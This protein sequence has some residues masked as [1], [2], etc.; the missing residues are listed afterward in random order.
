M[1]NADAIKFMESKGYYMGYLWHV[2]DVKS[3]FECTDEEAYEIL[4]EVLSSDWLSERIYADIED[5][6]SRTYECKNN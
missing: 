1:E 3:K 4:N 5:I 2:D 6:A